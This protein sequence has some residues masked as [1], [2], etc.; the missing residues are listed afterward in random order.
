[1]RGFRF[2]SSL[3]KVASARVF[4]PRPNTCRPAADETK[5][6]VAWQEKTSGTQGT[7]Y[8]PDVH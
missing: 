5:F 2:R 8:P 4:G 7:F 1:M 3:K 6:P